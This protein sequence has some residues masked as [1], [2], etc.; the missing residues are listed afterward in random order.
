MNRRQRAVV[1]CATAL[2]FLAASRRAA[3]TTP[4][5]SSLQNPIVIS[6]STAVKP[7]IALLSAAMASQATPQTLIYSGVGSCSGVLELVNDDG[8]SACSGQTGACATGNGTF[9]TA[10]AQGSTTP[11]SNTCNFDTGG[12]HVDVAVSDV[13][14]QTCADANSLSTTG[15]SDYSSFVEAMTFA[16]PSAATGVQAITAEEAYFVLGFP[17]AD[18][19]TSSQTPWN[20]DADIFVRSAT[21]GTQIVISGAIGV[22]AGKWQGTSES[23]S[24][25]VVM[26]LSGLTGSAVNQGLG[27]LGID[28]VEGNTSSAFSLLA[29]KAFGQSL[30]YYP[31]S[32]STSHD[33]QNVR[34]GHYLLW[35]YAHFI[36]R[37]G[38]T[39]GT[40]TPNGQAVLDSVTGANAIT[41]FN[42]SN[43]AV[44]SYYIPQCAMTVNRTDDSFTTLAPY[45]APH[46]CECYYEATA[47]GTAP[48]SCTACQSSSTCPS[49]APV[50][51][52]G[53]C[54]PR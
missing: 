36:T 23:G 19:I 21:S 16:V 35:G 5:C 37:N 33:K 47:T 32:T 30:A 18:G 1:V 9:W 20:N 15:F 51:T 40:A 50:C 54:E 12:N 13:F 24:G 45:S 17:N 31:D 52:N 34:D 29:F 38:E 43:A 42:P 4:N 49:S 14:L 6:G 25:N 8:V 27:I 22:P 39:A 41:G 11:T 53:Y 3:A 44:A 2:V 10:P 26:G 28:Y 46:P 48:A 7:Y